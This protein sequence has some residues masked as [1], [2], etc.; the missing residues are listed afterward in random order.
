MLLT[1]F[2]VLTIPVAQADDPDVVSITVSED[3]H[4]QMY[5]TQAA[6]N[7]G[8]M[9][10]LKIQTPNANTNA[11]VPTYGKFGEGDMTATT[12]TDGNTAFLRFDGLTADQLAR[13]E[14]AELV[15]TFLGRRYG[16]RGNEQ[17]LVV[18]PVGSNWIEGARVHAAAQGNEIS[19]NN[20]RSNNLFTPATNENDQTAFARSAPFA[21]NGTG[22][23]GGTNP[24]ANIAAGSTIANSGNT[25][26]VT[27]ITDIVKAMTPGQTSLNLAINTETVV[28]N[29]TDAQC[30]QLFFISK[31][32]AVGGNGSTKITAATTDMAPTLKLTLRSSALV[33]VKYSAKADGAADTTT[34]TKIDFTFDQDV[35][36]L[37]A[38]AVELNPPGAA[39]LGIITGSGKTWSIA[40]S[41]VVPGSVTVK[42]NN[43]PGFN[44]EP[45]DANANITTLF[46]AAGGIDILPGTPAKTALNFNEWTTPQDVKVNQIPSRAIIVPFKDAAS[47]KANPTL[48]LS[49]LSPDSNII[50]LNGIW[51]FN[52]SRTPS[53]KPDVNG[54]T[55]IP[56]GFDI[57]MTVPSSWQ[58]NMQYAGWYSDSTA[59]MDWPIYRNQRYAWMV[60]GDGVTA[61]TGWTANFATGQTS[62]AAANSAFNPVGTYMRTVDINAADIGDTRFIITFLGVESGFYLYVN[63][64]PVGYGEDTYT[65]CEFDI[66]EFVKAGQNLITAQVY[67]WTTGSFLEN[68]DIVNYSGIYRDVYITKQPKVS[69]FDYRVDTDFP[70]TTNYSSS[71]LKL[72]VD[73]EN[74]SETAAPGYSV[75]ATLY[76]AEGSPV[77]NAAGLSRTIS[78]LPAGSR[79]KVPFEANIANPKL[80][81]AE[82][83]YLYTLVMELKDASGATLEA[84][85]KRVGFRNFYI[86]NAGTTNSTSYMA[87]NGQNVQLWGAN[88]GQNNARGGRAIP[89]ED[90]VWDVRAAKE[91][92]LNAFRTSHM[93]PCPHLIE[94]CDEYGIYVMDEVNVE[95]HDGR[96]SMAVV[97][98]TVGGTTYTG[99][100]PGGDS[101][102][103]NSMRT[104]M[105]DMV[106]RDRNNASV[107]IYS[108]G[109]EAGDGTNFDVM[110]DVIK[111]GTRLGYTAAALDP[112]KVIHYQGW[113]GNARVDIVGSMYPSYTQN[114]SNATKPYIMMEYEHAL[115]NT[116]GAFDKYTNHFESNLRVQGGFIWEYTDHSVYTILPASAMPDRTRPDI[117]DPANANKFFF[118]FDGTWKQNSGTMTTNGSFC[119]DGINFPDRTHKP[120]VAEVRKQQQGLKFAQTAAMK[121]AK[122]VMILNGYAFLNANHFDVVWS[123]LEDGKVLESAS[124]DPSVVDLAANRNSVTASVPYPPT[125]P[126]NSSQAPDSAR[127]NFVGTTKT[128]TVPYSDFAR[129]PGAEYLLLI[130]YKLKADTPYAAAG[131]VQGSEQFTLPAG[132]RGEDKYAEIRYMEPLNVTRSGNTVSITGTAE[133]KPFT[134]AFN[135]AT[136]LMTTYNVDS[137][138]LIARAPV[139]SFY[140]PETDQNSGIGGNGYDTSRKENYT[141]WADQGE[142][143]TVMNADINDDDARV[144]KVRFYSQLKNGSSYETKYDVYG[145]GTVVVSAKLSP[146]L[147]S[148]TQLG[149][150]GMWMKVNPAFENI[151]WYGR[152][153]IETY[154]DRKSGQNIGVN[155]GTVTGQYVPYVRIQENGNKT[156]VRW[157]S[158]RDGETGPGLLASMTYGVNYTGS[159]LE[160]VALHYEPKALSSY[161]SKS[162]HTYQAAWS[163]EPVLRL[164][165]HQKGVGNLNWSSE[166]PDAIVN[167][168]N[169]NLLEYTYTLTP[170][171]AGDDAMNKSKD[172]IIPA[173]VPPMLKAVYINGVSLAGYNEKVREYSYS[174][175]PNTPFPTVTVE[176]YDNVTYTIVPAQGTTKR[177][178]INLV[179]GTDEDSYTINWIRDF[180]FL[181]GISLSGTALPGFT[182]SNR[183]F[184]TEVRS[185]PTITVTPAAGITDIKI[186]QPTRADLKAVITVTNDF[187]DQ[188]IYTIDFVITNY[189]TLWFSDFE[190]NSTWSFLA[191]NSTTSNGSGTTIG[192]FACTT[193]AE[194]VGG[195]ETYKLKWSGSGGNTGYRGLTKVFGSGTTENELLVKFDWYPGLLSTTSGNRTEIALMRGI[196]AADNRIITIA[197]QNGS[198]LYVYTGTST[199]AST[200]IGSGTDW[201]TLTSS[202]IT[203]YQV[204]IYLTRS[205]GRANVV[206]TNM[207]TGAVASASDINLGVTN[208]TFGRIRIGCTRASGDAYGTTYVDNLGVYRN[209]GSA[210][211][212]SGLNAMISLGEALIPDEIRYDAQQWAAFIAALNAAKA[213]SANASATQTEVEDARETLL[214]AMDMALATGLAAKVSLTQAS[215]KAVAEFAIGNFTGEDAKVQCIIAIY[216]K[217]GRLVDLETREVT[218]NA[219]TVR[220][221]GLTLDLPEGY[222]AKAFVWRM[223]LGDYFDSYIPIC[224]AAGI[225]G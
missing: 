16:N 185:V 40:I 73:V 37:T 112:K 59:T 101:R 53:G 199:T 11:P 58:T 4:V 195:N 95:T 166:P 42:L 109:N 223:A 138:D 55:S 125:Y 206:V 135:T 65:S 183:A 127:R 110:I 57:D 161:F 121:N 51:K 10:L 162:L 86:Y 131:F 220:K 3:A 141:D 214:A 8:G 22:Y 44:F 225:K 56:A 197:A 212:K 157:I 149:E 213:V 154:W 26:A 168:N 6:N 93:P 116:G 130:E 75:A 77:A 181:N 219:D 13:V 74:T 134:V 82:I 177:T 21:S 175:G 201:P 191:S 221:E 52:Y 28:V 78:A 24:N 87:I 39:A 123:I 97:G 153:P 152:G 96:T 158:L 60:G 85:S 188:Q 14:K 128:I 106:M 7:Y 5:S 117:N 207:F 48:R 46:S 61:Q 30:E 31:E 54:V 98:G 124:F 83:P 143:M 218:V 148:P 99:G 122:Q 192:S 137:K 139:G 200:T 91:M 144:T 178:V 194:P 172:I 68:Q 159:P 203:W 165:T 182:K 208:W 205:T 12:S 35:T 20:M 136:G 160:A 49:Q 147:S 140:R 184:K 198:R 126:E 170:L 102:Y 216:D 88:R 193:T 190:D 72:T 17:V 103:T 25:K 142:D 215:G 79:A 108:L 19:W 145:N 43:I 224:K 94:L 15:M 187:G 23:N 180:D 209:M 81:S 179:L 1:V 163:N 189:S 167:K 210:V 80:W 222:E 104:R 169:A 120:M 62:L 50:M 63:G 45:L 36:G 173:N 133:G 34:S 107:V 171:F 89:Y 92:N 118:G 174:I 164:L 100:F 69:I 70:S 176:T 155:K 33:D 151:A 211:D 105:T 29:E 67:R 111:G 47:A 156:D 119:A 27:D 196:D 90:V 113:N 204:E 32:G 2:P 186:Q 18:R 41:N 150:F 71:T 66:T 84:V 132:I 114:D 129:K 217:Q 115:G 202:N 9:N 64:N 146:S 38:G 76:D